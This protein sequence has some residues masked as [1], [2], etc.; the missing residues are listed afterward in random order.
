MTQPSMPPVPQRHMQQVP[1]PVLP[2]RSS[3][4]P[5]VPLPR[6]RGITTPERLLE[7]RFFHRAE[8]FIV[9]AHGGSGE[10][11]IA[12]LDPQWVATGHCFPADGDLLI[13][14]KR[15]AYGL[16]CGRMALQQHLSGG[17]G[18]SRLMGLV[19]IDDVP[20]KIP[21]ELKRFSDLVKSLAPAT[22]EVP[23]DRMLRLEPYPPDEWSGFRRQHSA[24]ASLL[25]SRNNHQ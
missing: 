11:V 19:L 16:E 9:G 25:R 2:R 10:S 21:K 22:I 13:C 5:P 7:I 23:F 3:R 17:A 14:C 20:G 15:S 4:V 12:G 8:L 1:Q 6:K 24:I 18:C